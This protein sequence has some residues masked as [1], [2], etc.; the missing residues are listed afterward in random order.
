[1][2]T[3]GVLVSNRELRW[4]RKDGA[5]LIVLASLRES[6]GLVEGIV[7]DITDRK[8]AEVADQQATRLT[9]PP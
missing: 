9:R 8:W 2:L 5:P 4:R 6:H 3:P 7:I 1:M